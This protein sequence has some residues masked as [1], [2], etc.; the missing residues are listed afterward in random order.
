MIS[1]KSFIIA[2][3]GVNKSFAE[4]L[5]FERN[6]KKKFKH[7]QITPLNY[8]LFRKKIDRP[9]VSKVQ[10]FFLMFIFFIEN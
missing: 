6:N 8:N 10:Y 3:R 9:I 4:S 2:L 7:M 1:L 5:V